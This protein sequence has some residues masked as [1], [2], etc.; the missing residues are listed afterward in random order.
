MKLNRDN[1]GDLLTPIHKKVFFEEY[2][3]IPEQYSKIFKV[4]SMRKKQ[5]T[6]P[7]MGAFGMWD[8]NTEGNTINED[9]MSQGE[10]ATLTA[11]RYDKGY[12]VTW[13]LVQD[14]LN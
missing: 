8:T 10:T 11:V 5:E 9:Q 4:D 7:H 2:N 13:E 12:S 3:E 6:F 14:D 1:F